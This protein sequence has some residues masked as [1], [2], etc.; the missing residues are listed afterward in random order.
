MMFRDFIPNKVR[1][2]ITLLI[3]LSFQMSG[4]VYLSSA[5]RMVGSM[6]VMTEDIMMAGYASFVGMTMIFPV[7]FRLKFRFTTRTILLTV[8]PVLIACNIAAVCVDNLFLLMAICFV[9]GAF[10]MWGTFECL[11]NAQLSITETRNF[12]VF[13]PVVYLVVLGTIQ[14]SGLTTVHIGEALGWQYMHWA[15]VGLLLVVWLT[16]LLLTRHFRFMKAMPLKGIDWIGGALWT[17]FL[18]ALIFVFEYGKYFDW[19]D[20]W[21]IRAGVATAVVSLLLAVRRM[22][23]IPQPYIE[24]QTFRYRNTL[25]IMLLFLL[26][27][28]LLTP[29]MLLQNVLTGGI[30]HFDDLNTVTLNWWSFA[31]VLVGGALIYF[32]HARWQGSYKAATFVGFGLIVVYQ[33]MMYFLID[34]GL[35]IE[36]LYLPAF[37]RSIGYIMLYVSLTVYM[38]AQIPFQHF[39][40]GLAIVG[41]IRTGFGGPLGEAVYEHWLEMSMASN[42]GNLSGTLDAVNPIAAMMPRGALISETMEQVTLVSLKEIFGWT[43]IGGIILLVAILCTRYLNQERVGRLPGMRRIKRVMKRSLIP[44]SS[45]PA[46]AA[47]NGNGPAHKE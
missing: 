13:F 15:I 26:L 37:L 40:Q 4:G 35:D 18:L 19:L 3:A 42:L 34:P 2:V 12:A 33:I 9:A 22:M 8:C 29:F 39:F 43:C 25:S 46:M 28:L 32:W 47:P 41:F 44:E 6:A 21:E 30:L 38:T 16:I 17:I 27:E 23:T 36:K 7:L 20:A 10:R 5:S 45:Q 24:L 31:G 14:L 11:S 1:L